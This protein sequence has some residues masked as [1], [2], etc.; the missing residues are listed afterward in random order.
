MAEVWAVGLATVAVGAYGAHQAGKAG[1]AAA[2]GGQQSIA[3]QRRQFDLTRQDQLPFLE[4]G[5]DALRAQNAALKGD[6][7]GF[8]NSPDYA[9]AYQQGM[10]S[11]DRG[12]IGNMF[13]GGHDADRIVLGQGLASQ[14]FN[15][16]WSRLA[17][18]AG[19]GQQTA[20]NLGS[21]GGQY[22]QNV[23]NA[24][25]DMA[26]ARASSYVAQGNAWGNTVGQLGNLAGMYYGRKG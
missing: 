19:Q 10:R 2:E 13:G 26:N 17:G 11:L 21:L 5:Y 18:R 22:A 9:Y 25:Q 3:E 6:F 8:E 14:N 20:Q 16:Y 1:D 4:A 23:G 24:Y 12:S 15:N 7:S